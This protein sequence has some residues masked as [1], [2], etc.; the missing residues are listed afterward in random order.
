MKLIYKYIFLFLIGF[1]VAS[2]SYAQREN[3]LRVELN[4]NLDMEDYQLVPCGEKG[5]LVFFESESKGST[6]DTKVWHFAYYDKNFKQKWLADTALA[7][8]VKFKGFKHANGQTYLFFLNSDRRKSAHNLQIV[9]VNFGSRD[10]SLT[11]TYVPEKS[12]LLNTEIISGQAVLALNNPSFVPQIVFIDLNNASANIVSPEIEGL[13]ILQQFTID[14]DGSDMLLVV[15]NYLG[16]KQNVIMILRMDL[17]GTILNTYKIN[18]AIENKVLNSARIAESEGDTLLIIGTYSND[19]SKL[20]ENTDESGAAAAG[21]FVTKF[22]GTEEVFINYF[23]FLE[24]EEMYRS[25]SSKTI[26]DI[27]S[28]AEKQK[29]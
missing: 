13:N 5:I 19:I 20:S 27:R 25:M 24:F 14:E 1:F 28:K 12:E 3:P 23:N 22:A 11:N 2:G 7:A 10:F 8:G 15:E 29:A 16:K 26:A 18:P 6:L 9:K 21:Y 17:S 4:A